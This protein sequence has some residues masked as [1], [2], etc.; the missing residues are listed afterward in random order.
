MNL[1]D[2]DKLFDH[3][4]AIDDMV[5]KALKLSEVARMARTEVLLRQYINTKWNKR[6]KKA[7][8]KATAMAK[9]LKTSSQIAKAIGKEMNNWSTDI[10]KRFLESVE[11]L[12]RNAR[13]A[14]WKKATKQTKASLSYSIPNFTEEIKKQKEVAEVLPA[15]DLADEAAIE[16]LEDHQLFWIED[17]YDENIS[18]SISTVTKQTMIEAGRDRKTAGKLM[19]E[20]IKDTLKHVR[21]PTGWHGSSEQY[22]EGLVANAATTARTHGQVRSFYDAGVT[23]Y[24][25]TNPMDRRTSPQ[26]AHL[27][28]KIFTVENGLEVMEAE[29]EAKTPEAIKKSHPWLSMKKLK[30]ISPKAGKVGFE[31]TQKLAS[32][33]FSLPPFHFRCRTTVDISVEAGSWKPL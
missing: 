26:C 7:V 23:R 4:V 8:K 25:L 3:I 10:K 19:S 17:F 22:F 30:E 24:E 18:D 9:A 13:I 11:K 33:G 15:F 12:Y 1:P 28:G 29:L 31:D 6:L 2:S 20:R 16:A 14:G 5:A 21:T 27:N 32:A